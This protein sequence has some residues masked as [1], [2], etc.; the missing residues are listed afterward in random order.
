[1]ETIVLDFGVDLHAHFCH[2]RVAVVD[3]FWGFTRFR[4]KRRDTRQ[5]VRRDTLDKTR[6]ET[7]D[8]AQGKTRASGCTIVSGDEAQGEA[9]G[10]TRASG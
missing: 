3:D 9:R 2:H 4:D 5:V 8:E 7:G 6:D 10:E 1:M